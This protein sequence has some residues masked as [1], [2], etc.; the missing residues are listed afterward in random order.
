MIWRV[1]CPGVPKK[2]LIDTCEEYEGKHRNGTSRV[3]WDNGERGP[4]QGTKREASKQRE[5]VKRNKGKKTIITERNRGG[6]LEV[7]IFHGACT[8]KKRS[9]SIGKEGDG[10]Q[11]QEGWYKLG[12]S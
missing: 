12:L 11:G 6:V 4:E 3:P 7:K 10:R 8:T 9:Q 5:G 1:L 2:G